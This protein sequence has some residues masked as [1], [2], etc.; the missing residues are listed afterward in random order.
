MERNQDHSWKNS[1]TTLCR[2][3]EGVSQSRWWKI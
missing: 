2:H 1:P 3:P